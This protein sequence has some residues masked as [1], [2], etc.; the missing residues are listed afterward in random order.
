MEPDVGA[1]LRDLAGRVEAL[2]RRLAAG[3][4]DAALRQRGWQPGPHSPVDRLL[5]PSPLS[6]DRVDR[7]YADLHRY[8]FRRLLQE[9]V[10]RRALTPR[11]VEDLTARWGTRTVS[12]TLARLEGYGLL[13]RRGRGYAL[14]APHP[15]AFGD[16]LEW[17]VAQV[18]VR[19]FAAPAAW[20]VRIRDIGRGGDFD[21]LAV[22][23]GGLAYVECKA[24]PPYN[25]E[26][27][28]LDSFLGRVEAL[29]PQLAVF[30]IDTTLEVDRNIIDN[31]RRLL[32]QR[33]T[34]RPVARVGRGLYEWAGRPPLYVVTA[35]RSLVANLRTCLRRWAGGGP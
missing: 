14:A 19:E 20:D 31:L 11:V 12:A 34:P 2:E 27:A 10:E 9:A 4:V 21:V 22:L 15:R 29:R 30:L 6:S 1:V 33:G 16:T 17:F 28:S 13:R 18:F 35:R 25:V 7:F 5:L 26:A 23:G 8:H 24:S 3:A 32:E